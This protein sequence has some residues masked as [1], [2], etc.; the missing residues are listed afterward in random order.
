MLCVRAHKHKDTDRRA[1]TYTHTHTEYTRA[2]RTHMSTRCVREA[3]C[4][5][6]GLVRALCRTGVCIR[7]RCD[8]LGV[9]QVAASSHGSCV[10][11]FVARLFLNTLTYAGAYAY[12]KTYF[13]VFV[14]ACPLGARVSCAPRINGL[15]RAFGSRIL[16]QPPPPSPNTHTHTHTRRPLSC[17]AC[18][19]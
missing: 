16:M 6:T 11:A 2:R 4:G 13:I 14:S 17:C 9:A 18:S 1:H 19:H 10:T 12:Y 15:E 8:N 7:A 3:E 5:C